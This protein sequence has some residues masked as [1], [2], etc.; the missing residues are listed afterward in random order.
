MPV[1]AILFPEKRSVDVPF[2]PTALAP[3]AGAEASVK[4]DSGQAR[5][6]VDY[7]NL[8]PALA[9]G[10]DVSCYVLWAL[11]PGG[12]AENLGELVVTEGS[13]SGRFQTGQKEFGMLV[14]AEAYP[15]VTR[16]STLIVFAS[17]PTKDK[18]SKN[19]TFAYSRAVPAA[20]HDAASVGA[21]WTGSEPVA[22]AQARRIYDTAQQMG[23]APRPPPGGRRWRSDRPRTSARPA[24]RR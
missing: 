21:G 22:V 24:T 11:T 12:A 17:M 1:N 2:A 8:A 10:G 5:I 14:T 19:S 23:V 3:Q 15:Q 7:K 16:P 6:D 9:F 4:L 20:R 13:G 18:H